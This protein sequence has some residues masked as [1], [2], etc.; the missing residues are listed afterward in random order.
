MAFSLTFTLVVEK[1]Q[2]FVIC[3]LSFEVDYVKVPSTFKLFTNVTRTYCWD[4]KRSLVPDMLLA[5]CQ[6]REQASKQASKFEVFKLYC[7]KS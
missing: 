5:S 3:I 1:T 6:S 7:L 2:L 4:L